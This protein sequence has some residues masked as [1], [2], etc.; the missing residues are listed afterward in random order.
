MRAQYPHTDGFAANPTDGARI[1][2]EVFGPGDASR[3]IV[4]LPTWTIVHGHA[5]VYAGGRM[6]VIGGGQRWSHRWPNES[7]RPEEV[8]RIGAPARGRHAGGV[9]PQQACTREGT[10]T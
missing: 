7:P 2:Y 8:K 3:T 5:N 9:K 1:F 4:F 10:P 6:K